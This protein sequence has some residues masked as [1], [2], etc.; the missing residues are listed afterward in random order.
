MSIEVAVMIV[1]KSDLVLPSESYIFRLTFALC[2]LCVLLGAD[3]YTVRQ[4]ITAGLCMI[5][6]AAVY[7]SSGRNELI[8]MLVF[9]MACRGVDITRSIRLYFL[10]SLAGCLLL[11]VL[12]MTGIFGRLM[13]PSVDGSQMLLGL[14]MGNANALHCMFMMEMMLMLWLYRESIK[15][16]HYVLCL[17]ANAGLFFLTGC[18]TAMAIVTLAVGGCWLMKNRSVRESIIPYI[19]GI[20]AFLFCIGF[21]VWAAWASK[22]TW[23]VWHPVI[24]KI[25]TLLTGRIKSLYWNW[26]TH[27][28]AVESWHLLPLPDTEYYFDMGWCRLFYW[29]GILPAICM[30]L[31][32]LLLYG[33]VLK[34][35]DG[36]LL[37]LLTC[38][39]I[40]T[41]VEAHLVSV[42]IGRNYLLLFVGMYLGYEWKEQLRN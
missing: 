24:Q 30:I 35:R 23:N 34:K 42:Y 33:A 18:D 20:A 11:A 31:I 38:L 3:R 9:I 13:V 14:G 27:P 7:I 29:Y 37:V 41:V 6:A 28:G 26:D 19:A 12:S 17:A 16:Y 25:D 2:V 22:H 8:R 36:T 10:E 32:I 4:W 15:W 1:D 5:P 39:S 21:S 40:Y